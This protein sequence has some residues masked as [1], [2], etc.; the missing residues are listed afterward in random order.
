MS[1]AERLKAWR[2]ANPEKVAAH[3]KE[4]YL[5]NRER[6]LEYQREYNAKNRDKV[7]EKSKAR[8]HSVTEE[9]RQERYEKRRNTTLL[10]RY[11]ISAIQYDIL[12]AKQG[13]VCKLCRI[14]GRTGKYGMLDVDHC[15]KT[16]K[17]RGLL[18][19]PCNH[20]LGILGDNTEGLSR[21]LEYVKCD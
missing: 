16:N 21:A 2:K 11:G 17:V 19:T 20:A 13:G 9:Q 7:L 15:H 1:K 18:C 12:N 8:W 4:A 6:I 5:K 14:P 3:Q 10:R